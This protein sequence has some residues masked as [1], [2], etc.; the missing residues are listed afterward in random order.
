SVSR[1][2]QIHGSWTEEIILG[3][4]QRKL[5]NPPAQEGTSRL[6]PLPRHLW[7]QPQPGP[8]WHSSSSFFFF[9]LGRSLALL[10][11]LECSGRISARCKL[12]LP[13][14]RHSPASASRVAGTTGARQLTRLVFGIF[15]RDGVSPC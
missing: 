11:G 12:R 9:F 6:N 8:S 3:K 10:P 4:P 5:D 2:L 14:S 7:L 1:G 15:S 13:G